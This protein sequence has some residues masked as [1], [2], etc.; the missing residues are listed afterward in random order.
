MVVNP[1]HRFIRV[2]LRRP[3][4]PEDERERKQKE[5]AQLAVK[6][7]AT[8]RVANRLIEAWRRRA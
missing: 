4:M 6:Y 2:M 3:P 7:N 8:Q 5:L 1:V